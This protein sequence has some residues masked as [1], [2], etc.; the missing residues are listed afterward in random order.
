MNIDRNLLIQEI[1]S[2]G[3]SIRGL[4]ARAGITETTAGAVVRGQRRPNI[5]T[6]GKISR[7]LDV[8][9]SALM[10]EHRG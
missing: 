7:A 3:L 8:P 6:A 2:Q 10:I 9:L 4:A 5:A 1:G